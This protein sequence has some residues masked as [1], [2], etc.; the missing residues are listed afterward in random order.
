LFRSLSGVAAP[1]VASAAKG[2]PFR[3]AALFTHRGLSGPAILQ[4]SSYWRGGEAINVDFIPD[5]DQNWLAEAKRRDP[6]RPVRKL[7]EERLPARLAETLSDR[8]ALDGPIGGMSDAALS[9]AERQLRH[10]RFAPNGSEGYAKAEV[11][12]GGISTA[13]L[14]SQT[15]AAKRVPGLFVIGEAVDVTGWLGGYNFQWAW[16]SAVAAGEAA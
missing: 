9:A 1:V 11:T 10:W 13:E 7:V 16:A 3:E 14:S 12:S 2:P 5:V 15:M 6:R 8:L 4:V